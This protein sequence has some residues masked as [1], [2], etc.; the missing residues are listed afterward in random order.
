MKSLEKLWEIYNTSK[1]TVYIPSKPGYQPMDGYA[2]YYLSRRFYANSSL[3]I[4]PVLGYLP[5]IDENNLIII[6]RM[7][8]YQCKEIIEK[9]MGD[10][11]REKSAFLFVDNRKLLNT[12]NC[13]LLERIEKPTHKTDFGIVRMVKRDGRFIFNIAGLGSIGTMG[14]M[15]AITL[16]SNSI[17]KG[18]DLAIEEFLKDSITF[19]ELLIRSE[20]YPKEDNVVVRPEEVTVYHD[21]TVFN[22]KDIHWPE[23]LLDYSQKNIC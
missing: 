6:G 2:L 13:Q 23:I 16:P 20:W 3:R 7:W 8:V 10:M 22:K 18:I 19:G 17:V 9:T 14:A 11:I 12:Q 5:L 21:Q 15:Q 1:S 4:V